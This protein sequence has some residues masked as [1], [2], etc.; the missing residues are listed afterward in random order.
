MLDKNTENLLL[1][2]NNIFLAKFMKKKIFFF[3]KEN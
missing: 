2:L 1:V 3:S